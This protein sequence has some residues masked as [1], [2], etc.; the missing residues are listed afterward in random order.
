MN[1]APAIEPEAIER[2]FM[3]PSRERSC[4]SVHIMAGM[5]LQPSIPNRP[6][7]EEANR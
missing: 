5:R 7:T 1:E 3:G 2:T 6:E 4:A